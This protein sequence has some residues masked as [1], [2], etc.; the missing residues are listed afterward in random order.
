[1]PYNSAEEALNHLGGWIDTCRMELADHLPGIL[2]TLT[3]NNALHFP[4]SEETAVLTLRELGD[5]IFEV[6]TAYD[7]AIRHLGF[8]TRF[9]DWVRK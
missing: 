1:M 8:K 2:E 5:R 7:E 4:T 9:S 3:E 6:V